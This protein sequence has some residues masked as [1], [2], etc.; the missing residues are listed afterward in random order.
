[1]VEFEPIEG[2]TYKHDYPAIFAAIAAGR[3]PTNQVISVYRKLAR[4]DLFFLL[5]FGLE[6]IDVNRRFV[7]DAIHD[8]EKLHVDVGDHVS[9]GQILLELDRDQLLAQMREAEANLLAAEADVSAAIAEL[10]QAEILAE[11]HDVELAR[12]N[13]QRS[14]ELAEQK[15][16]S[17]SAFDE[18]RGKL[19]EALNRQRA[20]VAGIGVSEATIKQRKAQVAQ[21][22]AIIDRIGEEIAKQFRVD[23]VTVRVRKLQP[24]VGYV[25]EAV[26]VEITRSRSYE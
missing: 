17:Q 4:E 20:A 12:S 24:P 6:R 2:M 26:E 22:Q 1:M 23:A 13:H 10:K 18:T 19:Q 14:I 9:P 8:V 3:I 15:L 11:E 7:I 25:V 21:F 16:I 5:Y